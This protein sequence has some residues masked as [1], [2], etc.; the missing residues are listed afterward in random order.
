MCTILL[1]RVKKSF[2]KLNEVEKFIIKSLKFDEPKL[3]DE[4]IKY[5][6]ISD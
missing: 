3:T 6:E 1:R 5:C 4:E 2:D